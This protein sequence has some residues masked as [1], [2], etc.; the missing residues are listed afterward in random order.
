MYGRKSEECLLLFGSI[1]QKSDSV[2]EQISKPIFEI[3]KSQNKLFINHPNAFIYETLRNYVEFSGYYLESEP[4][5]VCNDPDTPFTKMRMS[6]IQSETKFEHSSQYIKFQETYTINE[7]EI[8]IKDIQRS[9]MVRTIEFLYN[10]KPGVNINELKKSPSLWKK[11]TT[12]F[13]ERGKQK[14]IVT[15]PIPITASNLLIQYSSFYDDW[16]SLTESILC[17]RCSVPVVDKF[18]VCP[19]CGENANQCQK[20]SF[21][22][23]NHPNA[24]LCSQCGFCKYAKFDY[25]LSAK[26]SFCVERITNEKE[27]KKAMETIEKELEN[28]HIRYTSIKDIKSQIVKLISES[29]DGREG[30]SNQVNE[31]ISSLASLYSSDCKEHFESLSKSLKLVLASRRELIRYNQMHTLPKTKKQNPCFGCANH[32]I[33]FCL[34]LLTQLSTNESAKRY[35]VNHDTLQHVLTNNIRNG[36]STTR[37]LARQLLCQLV[38]NDSKATTQ[39]NET[40]KNKIKTWLQNHPA[41][42]TDSPRNEIL[43]LSDMSKIEDSCW[44]DRLKLVFDILLEAV[45][46][47]TLK[48][49][50]CEQVI[51]PCLKIINRYCSWAISAKLEKKHF[52]AKYKDWKHGKVDYQSWKKKA[53]EN[54]I[55]EEDKVPKKE[56]MKLEQIKTLLLNPVS[57]SIRNTMVS[58]LQHICENDVQRKKHLL[59]VLT[60]MLPIC[61]GEESAQFFG[62]FKNLVENDLLKRYLVEKKFLGFLCKLITREIHRITELE[63]TEA[64]N[65]SQGFTLKELVELLVSFLD[66]KDIMQEF[67]KEEEHMEAVLNGF[68]SLRSLL[69]QKTKL[70]DSC[71]QLLKDLI[72]KLQESND[73]KKLFLIACIKVLKSHKDTRTAT[74]V[75][76]QMCNLVVPAKEEKVYLLELKR[77]PS[78]QMY[79]SSTMDSNPYSSAEI[80]P[81]M[82]NVRDRI[83][84]DLD[85]FADFK[86]EL[87]VAN[88]IISLHLPVSQVYEQVWKPSLQ[89]T[90][91]N[92]NPP[93]EIVYRFQGIDGD[94]TENE[95]KI[96]KDDDEAE[97]A[98]YEVTSSMLKCDGL[99]TILSFLKST[100]NLA[101]NKELTKLILRFLHYCTKVKANRRRLLLLNATDNLLSKCKFMFSKS[102][103]VELAEMLLLIVKELVGEA[104][105]LS[106]ESSASPGD[107][108][109]DDSPLMGMKTKYQKDTKE[110]ISQL[111]MF[112]DRLN[113]ACSPKIVD[114]ITGVLPYVTYGKEE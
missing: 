108:S 91:P 70:T 11:A 103:C 93:M 44:E 24:F 27:C 50:V 36:S 95:I 79:F 37:K 66:V 114:A 38:T 26:V 41:S 105:R 68:L 63:N 17:P 94:A 82:Q 81:L 43:L 107:S 90:D 54:V 60:S 58:I 33:S 92:D 31:Y 53:L 30:T 74:F 28:A 25:R 109:G 83:I 84:R 22:N 65:I 98:N 7:I 23:Y 106:S 34:K 86:L 111:K 15:F 12:C 72:A 67:K 80:G 61:S 64:T 10:N 56:M 6:D 32:L 5:L 2:A 49:Q 104:T 3:L 47:G 113:T 89:I 77:A 21:I 35:L 51:L 73:D 19:Y 102:D 52:V 110:I 57:K 99:R 71:A 75:F 78:Q 76:E 4:C 69:V 13:V 8:N 112:L 16:Q 46:Q 97:D 87:L 18:N 20:C 45:Q 59:R 101:E 42:I 29:T 1:S 9:R 40:V 55:F 14:V 85:I 48:L 39:L 88:N 96:L 62:L 100:Q